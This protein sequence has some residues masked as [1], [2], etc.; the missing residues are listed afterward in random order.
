MHQRNG[1]ALRSGRRKTRARKK[2]HRPEEVDENG[3]RK[4]STV[5]NQ[6]RRTED[7]RRR[8]DNRP[9]AEEDAPT[10][11][12]VRR[13]PGQYG[14]EQ[15]PIRGSAGRRS[16]REVDVSGTNGEPSKASG[17]RFR[18]RRLPHSGQGNPG[19]RNSRWNYNRGVDYWKRRKKGR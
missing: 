13:D 7:E 4:R 18:P 9:R 19:R 8:E 11:R 17:P 15:I 6:E 10:E 12:E 1:E 5:Q 3:E 16:R 2:E 14:L